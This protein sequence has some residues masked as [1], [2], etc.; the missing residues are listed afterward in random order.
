MIEESAPDTELKPPLETLAERDADIAEAYRNCGLP[1]MR[2]RSGDFGGLVRT[3]AAQQVSASAAKAIIERL[4]S[5]LPD[6]TPRAVAALDLDGARA[7]GLSRQKHGY[8]QGIAHA[9]LNGELDFDALARAD[10]ET[11]MAELTALKGVGRWTAESFLL[12]G[13][14][15]PDVFPAQ[16]LALQ[17]AAKRLKGLAERPSAPALRE[18]ADPWRPHRSA[19]ARFLWHIY[20]HPG[21]P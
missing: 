18:I 19:A 10:D 14:R 1:P 4:E 9:V 17:M 20:R 21:A 15:R 13:L 11:V 2:R 16:D 8:I 7:I 6:L 3:I 12:F 5:A